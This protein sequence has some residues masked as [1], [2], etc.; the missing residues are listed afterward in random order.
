VI[1]IPVIIWSWM[2]METSTALIFTV[3]MIPVNLI[4]NVLRPIIFTRGLKTP[5]LVIIV[6][7]IGGTLSNGIIGLFV[8]PIVLAVAW[9]L[10]V[11]FVRENDT[12]ST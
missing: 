9:D 3:Y 5:M 1:L 6:G 2:T 12:G 10:L 11:A 8:G 4:D 7:V